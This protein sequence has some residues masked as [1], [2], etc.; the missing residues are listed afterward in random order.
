MA[1][2]RIQIPRGVA[3]A[4]I[5]FGPAS[6]A[7]SDPPDPIGQQIAAMTDGEK[8]AQLLFVGF[9]GRTMNRELSVLVR[10]K[11]VGGLVLYASNLQSPEQVRRLT[12]AIK[13]A[14]G[15]PAA[16]FIA[17]D[18]EGGIVHRLRDG[19]PVVPSAMAIGAARSPE[20]ARRAGEQVGHAL[21]DLGFTMNFAPVLDVLSEP[22]NAA[23]GTR[24]FSD[25]PELVASLG[26][27]FVRGHEAA[28]I[29]A[30]A[31]HFP[32]GGAALDD[33]HL[34]LPVVEIGRDVLLGRELVPFRRAFGDGLRAVLSSH[35]ALPRITGSPVSAT[36]SPSIMTGLLRRELGFEGVAISDALQM[37]AL[38]QKRGAGALALDAILAGADMVLAL[39]D[40]RTRDSTYAF[41][42]EAYADGRLPAARVETALRRILT[43]KNARIGVAPPPAHV[44]DDDALVTEIARRAVTVA[45]AGSLLPVTPEALGRTLYVGPSGALERALRVSRSMILPGDLS[46]ADA[47]RNLAVASSQARRV[48]LIVAA[49]ANQ[50]QFDL[51]QKVHETMPETAIVFVNLGSP[52]RVVI[53]AA[54]CTIFTYAND[55]ASQ[56]AAAAVILGTLRASGRLPVQIGERPVN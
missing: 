49:A 43:L 9:D 21:A 31:K 45:G 35:V 54:A 48:S 29:I 3:L 12:A 23:I 55:P 14:G 38:D 4:V 56:R 41:L 11:R 10:T 46:P 22:R 50:A 19:V 37:K 1:L 39:G 18:Q 33:T 7:A 16:P 53:S 6:A 47:V 8:I 36:L 34:Q 27:A 32:G 20:L 40:A 52:H 42:L 44:R 2:Q 17:L 30:V 15:G 5:L 26:A 13:T 25:D 28:G 24:A 51:I